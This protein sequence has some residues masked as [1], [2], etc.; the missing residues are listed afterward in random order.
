[1][2]LA[3]VEKAARFPVVSGTD[4]WQEAGR[5]MAR[6]LLRRMTAGDRPAF[7]LLLVVVDEISVVGKHGGAFRGF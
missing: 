4:C 5:K 7:L 2:D 1:L 6:K 3:Q